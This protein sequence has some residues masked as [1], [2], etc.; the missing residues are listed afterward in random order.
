MNIKNTL[1]LNEKHC[2][3]NLSIQNSE[4]S[5]DFMLNDDGSKYETKE[6]FLDTP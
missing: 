1:F 6:I 4:R 3:S 2:K 5:D